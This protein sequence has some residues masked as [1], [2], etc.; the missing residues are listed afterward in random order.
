[1][2]GQAA[3]Q[4][5]LASLRSGG[6]RRGGAITWVDRRRAL[7]VKTAP[8][9]S[10]EIG[11]VERD[12]P[13]DGRTYLA[14]IVHEIGDRDRVVVVGPWPERTALEREYVAVY[15]RP[16][17]LVD[18]EPVDPLERA[19]GDESILVAELRRLAAS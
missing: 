16:E 2:H 8:D 18:L 1:M 4:S 14:R 12:V 17:R 5:T 3:R 9:G 19:A 13:G 6:P 10:V 11:R 7:I 15:Q